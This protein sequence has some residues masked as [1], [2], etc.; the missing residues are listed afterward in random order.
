M[1]LIPGHKVLGLLQVKELRAL[2]EILK[3]PRKPVAAFVSGVKIA[4]KIPAMEA[5]IRHGA[6]Q[7]LFTAS[8]AFLVACGYSVGNSLTGSDLI[9][10]ECEVAAAHRLIELAGEFN[11]CVKIP[12]DFHVGFE[13]PDKFRPR[14]KVPSQVVGVG[15]IPFGSC[16]FDIA[17]EDGSAAGRTS[18]EI[19]RILADART[20]IYNGT[21]GLYEVE[22]FA[23]GTDWLVGAIAACDA[24]VKLV[25]GGDGVTAV[26]RRMGG[27]REAEKVFTLCTGGG[28]AL[29]Y[30][31]TQNLSALDGVDEHR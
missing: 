29:K 31:A 16:V 2:D 23:T 3:D 14:L 6:I 11:A 17:A 9:E 5:M 13:M 8:P 21:V 18:D 15:K 12:K 25:V 28:A 22:Q 24:D 4:E 30:L 7:T 19:R 1:N 10:V 27:I 20:V 26:N